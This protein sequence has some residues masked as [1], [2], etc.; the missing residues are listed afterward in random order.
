MVTLELVI[1]L[2]SPG[3]WFV[4]IDLQDTYFHISI[5]KR[6]RKYF[7]FVFMETAYQFCALPFGLATAPRTFTEC[8][9]PVAA[10]LCLHNIMVFPYI[11]DWLIITDS[12]SKAE[13][14]T[15]FALQTLTDL[16]LQVNFT[17]SH[18]QLSQ[19]MDYIGDCLDSNR[20]RVFLP[21]ERIH[22]LSRIIHPFHPYAKVSAHHMQ[23][24]L[25]LLASTTSILPH[26]RLKMHSLQVWYQFDPLLDNPARHLHVTPELASQLTWLTFMPF[27]L[28]G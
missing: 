13:A 27:L 20:A 26:T 5:H 17:K 8:L 21:S 3:N 23:H 7:R 22:K 11:Y 15:N 18:L 9:A 2:L 4:V 24:L 16:G 25:G 14:D 12:Y 6:H 19:T 28:V 1:P 10:Y